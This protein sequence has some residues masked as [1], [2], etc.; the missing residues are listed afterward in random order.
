AKMYI[1]SEKW[2]GVPGWDDAI[3]MCNAIIQPGKYSLETDYFKNF[4]IS[5]KNTKEN[6]LVLPYDR[7]VGW[8]LQLHQYTLHP[9]QASTL[10]ITAPIWNGMVAKEAFYNLYDQNDKRINSW[11]VGQQY[12]ASGQPLSTASGAALSFTPEIN[13]LNSAGEIQ[14]VRCK[15]WEFSRD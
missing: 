15:K 3:S 6:I 1:N 11:M 2:T 7:R 13:A 14:G 4:M 8:G 10:N 12:N 5:N 9:A